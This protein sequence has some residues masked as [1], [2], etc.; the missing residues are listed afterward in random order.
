[1]INSFAAI[2]FEKATRHHVC[3]VGIVTVENGEIIDEYHALI[4]PPNNEY[5]WH[6]VQ[7]HGITENDTL[8]VPFFPEIFPEIKKRIYGKTLVA[9]NESFD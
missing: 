8:S 5:N 6:N 2:D 3:S 1:M 7:V 4:K 9:H